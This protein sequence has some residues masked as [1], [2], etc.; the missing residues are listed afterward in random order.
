MRRN[1]RARVEDRWT[2][3]REHLLADWED[4]HHRNL[5]A[6]LVSVCWRLNLYQVWRGRIRPCPPLNRGHTVATIWPQLQLTQ[7]T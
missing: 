4:L 3:T 6:D 2:K 1:R 5:M 7:V